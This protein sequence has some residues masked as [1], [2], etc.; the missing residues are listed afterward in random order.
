M[1]TS[2]SSQSYPGEI[3]HYEYG[4]GNVSNLDAS[5]PLQRNSFADLRGFV[6]STVLDMGNETC[7]LNNRWKAPCEAAGRQR[8]RW[9]G[10][11]AYPD[12]SERL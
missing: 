9:E 5:S 1:R 11:N 3:I 4:K 8:R 10:D 6:L 12:T 2:G 7:L